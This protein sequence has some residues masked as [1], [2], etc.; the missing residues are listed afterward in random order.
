MKPSLEDFVCIPERK[1]SIKNEFIFLALQLFI[2][3]VR[4]LPLLRFRVGWHVIE[5]VLSN[6]VISSFLVI[7]WT[8]AMLF[9][10]GTMALVI[11]GDWNRKS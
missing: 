6:F 3:M 5:N 2:I 9:V 11:F 7:I 1:I 4:F 8:F 10:L